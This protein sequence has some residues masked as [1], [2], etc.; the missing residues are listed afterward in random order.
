M[1]REEQNIQDLLSMT[2]WEGVLDALLECDPHHAELIE[3]LIRNLKPVQT[4]F[5]AQNEWMTQYQNN[6]REMDAQ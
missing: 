2:E 4:V 1:D 5:D 3:A 6:I